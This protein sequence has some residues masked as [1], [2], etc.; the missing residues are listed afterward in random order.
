MGI[1]FAG[2]GPT[3]ND[4]MDPDLGAQ[5]KPEITS[6]KPVNKRVRGKRRR[7]TL[8]AGTLNSTPSTAFTIQL[9]RNFSGEDEGR[10]LLAHLPSITTDANGN[11]SFGIRVRRGAAPVGSNITAAAT[12]STGGDTSE[13]SA[14]K[15]VG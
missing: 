9:F 7:F 12:D 13:F 4:D 10:T 1:D 3:S 5:N 6:A 11:A 14:P 15:T 8:I 2:D